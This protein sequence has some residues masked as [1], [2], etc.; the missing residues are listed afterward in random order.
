MSVFDSLRANNRILYT[1][2]F[3]A[4]EN[5]VYDDDSHGAMCF[6]TMG[7]NIGGSMVGTAPEASYILLR[8]EDAPTEKYY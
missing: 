7:A 6:S 3:V 4:H 2:D 5:N 1:Y 8:S